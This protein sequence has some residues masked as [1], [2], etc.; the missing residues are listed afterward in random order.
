M[1]E[2]ETWIIIGSNEIF[3]FASFTSSGFKGLRLLSGNRHRSSS[4]KQKSQPHCQSLI[5]SCKNEVKTMR[6]GKKGGKDSR[7]QTKYRTKPF[8]ILKLLRGAFVNGVHVFWHINWHTSRKLNL[9]DEIIK[10]GQTIAPN[11]CTNPVYSDW[12]PEQA[13]EIG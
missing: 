1:R 13:P 7:Q 8:L 10:L 12:N 3:S 2:E 11:F 9:F 5:I 4:W 6:N